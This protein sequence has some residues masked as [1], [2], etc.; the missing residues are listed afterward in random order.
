MAEQPAGGA[1]RRLH[2]TRRRVRLTAA[3]LAQSADAETVL[4]ALELSG[5]LPADFVARCPVLGPDGGRAFCE[6]AHL[7]SL[8]PALLASTA[9]HPR[10]HSVW[11]SLVP[12]VARSATAGSGAAEAFWD[13]VCE[14]NLFTSSHERKCVTAGRYRAAH[15]RIESAHAHRYLGFEIFSLLLPGLPARSVP[16]LFSHNFMRCMVNNLTKE[17]T[18]LHASAA[19]CL[20]N[21]WHFRVRRFLPRRL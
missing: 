5:Q 2:A 4:L 18:L 19:R 9:S 6:P 12:L 10:V 1:K 21:V 3:C 13:V 8:L 20:S 17:D 14:Q 15:A 16:A 7:S 11:S